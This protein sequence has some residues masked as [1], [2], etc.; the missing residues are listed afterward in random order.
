MTQVLDVFG[1]DA[2]DDVVRVVALALPV[3]VLLTLVVLLIRAR[4]RAKAKAAAS[5]VTAFDDPSSRHA[6]MDPV[7]APVALA[8]RDVVVVQEKPVELPAVAATVSDSEEAAEKQGN[9]GA[10]DA[11]MPP[12]Q[13]SQ[14]AIESLQAQLNNAMKSAQNSTLAPL[15]LDMARHHQAAGDESSYLAA[16]RSAA[17]L[18]AQHGPRAAHAQARLELAE[19]AFK[20]GDLIGACEQWQIARVALQDDGQKDA[21]AV[22]DKRMRDNGCPTDWVLTDF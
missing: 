4:R 22:V 6:P 13:K 18:A 8:A 19:A 20:S 3:L 10:P 12:V 17:G 21:Y 1:M 5:L 9:V 15:F 7:V 2:S 16:L 11:K 14:S